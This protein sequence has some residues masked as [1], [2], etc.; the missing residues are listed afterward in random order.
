MRKTK[1]EERRNVKYSKASYN[2]TDIMK[3]VQ[4]YLARLNPLQFQE[5]LIFKNHPSQKSHVMMK[6]NTI[7]V[8]RRP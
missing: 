7:Q 1:R 5:K 3:M 6:Q 4:N 8:R 2:P